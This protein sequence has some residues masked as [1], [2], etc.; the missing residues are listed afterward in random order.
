MSIRV[1]LADDQE[2]VRMGFAMIL[3]AADGIEVV[4]QCG[5][6]AEAVEA[7]ERIQPD[8]ALL[9]IRMPKLSGLDVTRRVVGHPTGPGVASRTAVVIVTTFG[10]DEYV[11]EALSLGASG[12][13]LKDSG[14]ALLVAA[15]R[16]AAEGDALI[17]P[18]LTV[19]L[20]ARTRGIRPALANGV[21]ELS[22]RELEVARLV[23]KGRTNAEI[24]ADLFLSVATVKTHLVNISA[25]LPARNRV[26]IAAKMW[27]SGLA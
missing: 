25:R 4:A 17:S 12:F 6:G 15:V 24:A 14:P 13:L 19:S 18:E 21:A 23:A 10:D 1:L 5:D 26:E 16:A 9:D 20:L 7:I 3:S 8:V 2:M 27:E 22:G 11:D